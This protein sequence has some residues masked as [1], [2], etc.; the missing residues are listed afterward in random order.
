MK[1]VLTGATGYLG[2][3]LAQRLTGKNH[4]LGCI[5]RHQERLG[6]LEPLREKVQLLLVDHLE[7][8][9]ASFHPEIIIHTACTYSRGN[10]TERD[11]LE[12][13]LFFP[14]RVMQAARDVGINRWINT[15][16]LL[17]PTLNSYAFAKNQFSQWG[18]YYAGKGEFA[19][20]N[21]I[22]EHFYGPDAPEEQFLPWVIKKL[23][24]NAPLELTAGTQRRDFV[25]IEDVQDVYEA[26]LQYPV[27]D[28]YTEIEVG[29]GEAPTIR[30]V[31]EYLKTIMHSSSKLHFGSVPM[32]DGE[33]SSHCNP[34]KMRRLRGCDALNWK[35]GLRFVVE[36][37]PPEWCRL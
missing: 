27:K 30:E 5:V 15:D 6:Y 32:R 21:L 37:I 2:S 25:Y 22:L 18:A 29:T 28:V 34:E 8:E 23:A 7:D 33:P 26:M 20:V 17:L 36:R 31:V 10:N 24:C 11:V 1:I 9:M 13:N 35:T 12:G 4:T 16:T 3:H 14:L 19:F